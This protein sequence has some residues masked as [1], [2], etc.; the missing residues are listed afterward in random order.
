MKFAFS[1]P[2]STVEETREL[3]QSFR[4]HGF[5]G[6]QLKYGQYEPYLDH[7]TRFNDEWGGFPGAAQALIAG[8]PLDQ[9]D[10]MQLERIIGFASRIGAGTLVYCHCLPRAGKTPDDLRAYARK[11]SEIGKI[12]REQG[13]RLSLH[14]H[15]DQ[16]VML[17]E[18]A[19]IFFGEVEDGAVGL[20]V[21]TAHLV[22]SGVEDVAGFI[23][24]FA[25]VIDNFHMKDFRDGRFAVLGRGQIDFRPVF[26]AVRG[27]GY[28]GW[29]SADEESG[30]GLQEAL[31]ECHTYLRR[32]VENS[33]TG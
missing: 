9:N 11:L 22:K 17:V 1:K 16:P 32:M 20:T 10:C 28:A 23:R 3:F 26:A 24:R 7:P 29:V 12:A 27:I 30:A 21:D 25:G 8:G 13:V 15:H 19:D 2:T 4:A 33:E 6:L 14:H 5:D 31:A 18:D